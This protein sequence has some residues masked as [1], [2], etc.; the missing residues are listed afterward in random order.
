[1]RN[2]LAALLAL[3]IFSGTAW[4]DARDMGGDPSSYHEMMQ[5][6]HQMMT[7]LMQMMKTTMGILKG[8]NHRPSADE[9]AQLEQMIKKLDQMMAWRDEMHRKM[10]AMHE[11]MKQEGRHGRGM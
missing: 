1:M 5:K 3:A 6:R 7:D 10:Q 2:L 8:L 9:Q 4:A 11:K